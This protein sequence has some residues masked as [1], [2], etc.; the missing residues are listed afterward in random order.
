[1]GNI[2]DG[3]LQPGSLSLTVYGSNT[4]TPLS[5]Q[6]G[7]Q[8]NQNL[9]V[10]TCDPGLMTQSTFVSPGTPN[11]AKTLVPRSGR[12][13]PANGAA[14]NLAWFG[15][16]KTTV[17]GGFQRT[18][19]IAGSAFSGG[20]VSGPAADG[21]QGTLQLTDPTIAA[22]VATRALNLSDLPTLVPGRPARNPG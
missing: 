19:G 14:R 1:R 21:T 2:F 20:L 17:R 9:P 22:I 16:G 18:Y 5:C 4:T 7:V 10:S 8:Q 15:D 13:D 11:P 3:W 6:N 12:S